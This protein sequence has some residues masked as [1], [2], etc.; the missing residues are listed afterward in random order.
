MV[1]AGYLVAL[2]LAQVRTLLKDLAEERKAGRCLDAQLN[3]V[4]EVPL[5]KSACQDRRTKL[6]C[7]ALIASGGFSCHTDLCPSCSTLSH[8]CDKMCGFCNSGKRRR[9]AQLSLTCP[10]ADLEA[11]RAVIMLPTRIGRG[12]VQ[13]ADAVER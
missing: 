4:A 3:G 10:I 11:V 9:R 1:S 13:W 2:F 12:G 7:V 8:Q 6:Q 5:V